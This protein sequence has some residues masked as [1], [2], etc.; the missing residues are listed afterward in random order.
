MVLLGLLL[1]AAG[2][3]TAIAVLAENTDQTS[4][5][6]FGQTV[7]DVTMGGLFLVG[8][9]VGAATLLGLWMIAAGL[10]RARRRRVEN[11]HVVTQTRTRAEELED[12]N[13]ELRARLE[14][15]DARAMTSSSSGSYAR[16]YDSDVHRDRDQDAAFTRDR[17]HDG[18]ADR[19][20]SATERTATMGAVRGD[21]GFGRD[22]DHDGVA[23]RNEAAP[24]ADR[25]VDRPI[26]GGAV[27]PSDPARGGS[28]YDE[29]TEQG[30]R[31]GLLGRDR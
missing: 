25:A 22:R 14:R 1:L 5:D 15:E 26:D 8:C 4:F 31:H 9:A 29:S 13:N 11:R 17:D 2:V 18:V 27:Y 3:T 20:E 10:K 24:Y 19:D 21:D 6:M 7:E 16:D 30:R 23:D 28:T 12:E